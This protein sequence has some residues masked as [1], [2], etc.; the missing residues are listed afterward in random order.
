MIETVPSGVVHAAGLT[1]VSVGL[2]WDGEVRG[3]APGTWHVAGPAS[4]EDPP[5]RWQCLR[6][7]SRVPSSLVCWSR[8]CLLNSKSEHTAEAPHLAQHV[9]GTLQITAALQASGHTVSLSHLAQRRARWRP[10]ERGPR[11]EPGRPVFLLT[12]PPRNTVL[13]PH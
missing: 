13:S 6:A 11:G 8:S 10:S 1:A 2:K 3:A 9:V 7:T 12:F 5:P 4:C